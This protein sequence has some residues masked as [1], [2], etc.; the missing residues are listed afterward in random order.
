M[1]C[2]SFFVRLIRLSLALSDGK[3]FADLVRVDSGAFTVAAI[4]LQK[5]A[6]LRWHQALRRQDMV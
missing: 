2:T 3:D 4:P 5:E 1:G 6:N